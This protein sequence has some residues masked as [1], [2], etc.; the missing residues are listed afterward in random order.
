MPGEHSDPEA[1]IAQQLSGVKPPQPGQSSL[2]PQGQQPLGAN[3][4]QA[5]ME[6]P[7]Q[8]DDYDVAVDKYMQWMQEQYPQQQSPRQSFVQ[9]FNPSGQGAGNVNQPMGQRPM[10]PKPQVQ[11]HANPTPNAA[12]Q[13][14]MSGGKPLNTTFPS[15]P[16]N[17]HMP[18]I[19]K[20]A[21]PPG[22]GMLPKTGGLRL[23]LADLMS[24]PSM[25]PQGPAS[26]NLNMLMGPGQPTTTSQNPMLPKGTPIVYP[27]NNQPRQMTSNYAVAPKTF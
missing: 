25:A 11:P 4:Q 9:Q 7:Y 21:M 12:Q 27:V 16:M 8:K 23:K 22:G 10:V 14:P 19:G 24:G 5:M 17:S 26:P 1:Q 6:Q 3:P 13:A 15:I 20:P 2:E 18:Q